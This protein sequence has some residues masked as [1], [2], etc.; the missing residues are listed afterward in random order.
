MLKANADIHDRL[1]NGLTGVIRHIEFAQGKRSSYLGI[2]N[3]WV[4]IEK[5]ET[6]ISIK[7]DQ[8]YHP[9]NVL[10]FLLH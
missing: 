3:S 7:K 4:S 1:I 5:W 10:N 2:L 8:H 9:S 6:E